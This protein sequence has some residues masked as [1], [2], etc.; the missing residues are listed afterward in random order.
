[1]DEEANDLA[2]RFG[3]Q[4]LFLHAQSIA[5]ADASGND[6]HFTAPLAPDLEEFLTVGVIEAQREKKSR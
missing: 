3:L 6:L 4:R 2:R 5:F 1:G